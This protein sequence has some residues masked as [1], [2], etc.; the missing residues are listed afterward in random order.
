MNALIVLPSKRESD[1]RKASNNYG[2]RAMRAAD[3]QEFYDTHGTESIVRLSRIATWFRAKW[4]KRN[5]TAKPTS[6]GEC[7]SHVC[8]NPISF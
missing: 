7:H 4:V 2:T 1:A 3:E 5:G 8:G 6:I